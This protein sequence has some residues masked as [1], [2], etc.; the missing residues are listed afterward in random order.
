MI[1][2]C[3]DPGPLEFPANPQVPQGV[4]R[5][6]NGGCQTRSARV[7]RLAPPPASD[8]IQ[9]CNCIII[10][11]S[12]TITP[13]RSQNGCRFNITRGSPLNEEFRSQCYYPWRSTHHSWRRVL[14]VLPLQLQTNRLLA[15]RALQN[16]GLFKAEHYRQA[17]LAV[18]A[19]IVI[20]LLIAA[21]VYLSSI[22][23]S[24]Y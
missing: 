16:P 1:S 6:K 12:S 10:Q 22:T 23:P 21:P 11:I 15:L 19:G 5:V 9:H 17:A 18:C 14:Y 2:S 20:R 3:N 4:E 24:F 7:A 13:V 8:G